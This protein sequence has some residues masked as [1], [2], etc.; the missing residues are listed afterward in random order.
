MKTLLTLLMLCC[1][2]SS[3]DA[4]NDEKEKTAWALQFGLG[5]LDFADNRINGNEAYWGE[6][7]ANLFYLNAD[8]FLTPRFALTGGIYWEQD[9]IMTNMA[10]GIGLRKYNQFGVQ[11]GAKF[12]FFP[13]RW[14]VQP[15][16][17][18]LL[19]TNFANLQHNRGMFTVSHIESYPGNSGFM[20]Y[21]IHCPAFSIAPQIGI[22]FHIFPSLSFTVD[23]DYR[24]GWWGKT[25]SDLVLTQGPFGGTR[26]VDERKM[27][28]GGLSIGLKLD[29]PINTP[30]N[31]NSKIVN[32][33]LDYILFMF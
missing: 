8:I 27:H 7:Q 32:N 2:F 23:Y 24:W 11:A 29:F 15:H 33:L 6:N 22:D 21:D 19:L 4:H 1:C 12:Y 26:F 20:S 17:G 30:S 14:I 10:S 5:R 31:K 3:T 13:K 16:I 18:G 25:R 28:R 9:G